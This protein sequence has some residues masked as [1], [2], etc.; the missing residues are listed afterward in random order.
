MFQKS[1]SIALQI[2]TWYGKPWK[3]WKNASI[4]ADIYSL[5]EKPINS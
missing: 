4:Q 5:G 2:P 1:K 3:N